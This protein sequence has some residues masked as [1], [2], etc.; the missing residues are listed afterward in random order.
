LKTAIVDGSRR[1]FA[2]S[3]EHLRKGMV[4]YRRFRPPLI[5][6]FLREVLGVEAELQGLSARLRVTSSDGG[7]RSSGEVHRWCCRGIRRIER[8]CESR[9]ILG[10]PVDHSSELIEVDMVGGADMAMRTDEMRRWLRTRPVHES[11]R[12]F[13][14]RHREDRDVCVAVNATLTVVVIGGRRRGTRR[15]AGDH[16]EEDEDVSSPV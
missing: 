6:S 12:N 13:A 15:F 14:S 7:L 11:L 3:N 1:S 2:D 5:D 9:E 8:G 16:V 4:D 10:F